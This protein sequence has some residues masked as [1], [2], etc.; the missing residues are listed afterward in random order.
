M[1]TTLV[2]KID[3][4]RDVR[5]RQLL[6]R[7]AAVLAGIALFVLALELVKQGAAGLLPVLRLL[8]VSG[9]HGALGFGWLMAFAVLSGSPV[10][11]TALALLAGGTL[12]PAESFAMI[13]GSRLGAAF[14]VLLVGAL[15]DIRARREEMRS[16]YIGVVALVTTALTYLPAAGLGLHGLGAGWLT[17]LHV[18]GRQ[19]ASFV[20]VLCGPITLQAARWLQPGLV[21]VIGVAVLLIAFR[22]FDGALPDAGDQQRRLLLARERLERPASMFAAGLAVTAV[23][24]S[25]SMSLSILVPLAA[26]R[27]VR[28]E[29]LW[30]YVLGANITTFDDTLFAAALVG[31][32]DAVR[33]V[34]LLI[35]TVTL[36]SAPLVFAGPSRFGAWID[37]IACRVTR[38][39]ASLLAFVG[40]LVLVPALLI[41]F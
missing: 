12:A 13:V 2:D 21:F 35:A 27:Y 19:L 26:R 6:P 10:A 38:E 20:S 36:F 3:V 24:M 15:D 34:A 1:S 41:A 7:A 14:V 8:Q 25:V 40:L 32:P 9:V 22:V 31:H 16:A 37:A 5:T 4:W 23:T 18:E 39:R 11:A 30:P 17:G 28:R 33:I 29:N